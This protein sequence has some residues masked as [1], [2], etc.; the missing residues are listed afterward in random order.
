MIEYRDVADNGTERSRSILWRSPA[1]LKRRMQ[2][3]AKERDISQ[4]V[5]ITSSMLIST[6]IIFGHREVEGM[7]DNIASLVSFMNRSLK[8]GQNI[9]GTVRREDWDDVRW[10][11]DLL[12]DSEIIDGRVELED[13]L[14][15][16][17]IVYSFSF[18]KDG[19]EVWRAIGERLTAFLRC[20]AQQKIEALA[21]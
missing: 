19:R 1:G 9:L 17:S 8:S 5:Y 21:T 18:T 6:L 11:I 12:A 15:G 16:D 3:G 2:E 14:S 20:V 13:G 7:P 4:N 10:F